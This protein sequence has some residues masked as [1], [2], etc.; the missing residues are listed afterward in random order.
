MFET[1]R[2]GSY[3]KKK[4][5]KSCYNNDNYKAVASDSERLNISTYEQSE[6]VITRAEADATICDNG[7][8][9]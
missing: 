9:I 6:G 5:K 8:S 4:N 7:S 2:F 1:I 3:Q